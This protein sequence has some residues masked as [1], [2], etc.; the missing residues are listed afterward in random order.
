MLERELVDSQT[1]NLALR[2]LPD[3]Q[4]TDLS[5]GM[6]TPTG[7]VPTCHGKPSEPCSQA[8]GHGAPPFFMVA[9]IV[10]PPLAVLASRR[11]YSSRLD[12]ESGHV[13]IN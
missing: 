1:S 12:E 3:P 9:V 4:F 13:N 7:A 11:R 8:P 2:T 5:P 6:I 10:G